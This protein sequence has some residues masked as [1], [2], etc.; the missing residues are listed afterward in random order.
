MEKF[1]HDKEHIPIFIKNEKNELI[2]LSAHSEM[3][4][5]KEGDELVYI[6]KK[7]V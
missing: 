5:V 1:N 7:I 3:I 6:G 4:E 2:I